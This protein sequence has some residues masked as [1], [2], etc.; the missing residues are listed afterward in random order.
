MRVKLK[1]YG[2]KPDFK[3][4]VLEITAGSPFIAQELTLLK[5]A[6]N[7]ERSERLQ[8]Q[9]NEY[10]KILQN[11]EPIYIPKPKDNRIDELEKELYKVKYVSCVLSL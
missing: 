10:K 9:A 7:N 8:L 11:L 3:S 5:K 2:T 4:T 1:A 6:F